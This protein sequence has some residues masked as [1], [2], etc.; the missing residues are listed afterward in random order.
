MELFIAPHPP[1]LLPEIGQGRYNEATATAQGMRQLS[2]D[3]QR[4]QPQIIAMITPH[5]N[6]FSD[7]LCVNIEPMLTGDFHKFGRRDIQMTLDG[8]RETAL[9]YCSR[10]RHA[11]INCLAMDERSA[12]QYAIST[13]LDH[14]VMVPLYFIRQ[15]YSTFQLLHISIGFLEPAQMVEA[16][17]ILAEL[18]G[19]QN[20]IVF[21]GD[22]SHKLSDD[23]PYGYDASGPVYD[24][25]IVDAI[26]ASRFTRILTLDHHLVEKAGQCAHKPL[27]MMVGALEGYAAQGTVYSY[28]G[29]FGV[30]YL[31][32]KIIRGEQGDHHRMRDAK[33][34][35]R[36]IRS[37]AQTKEDPYV[38]LA[39][40]TIEQYVRQGT[41]PDPPD[42]LPPEMMDQ[43]RGT[44]VSIKKNGRL[45]GCIGTISPTKKNIAQEIVGNAVAASTRDPRFEPIVPD[46]LQDLDISVDVLFP[47]EDIQDMSQLDVVKYGVIVT[48]GFR[49][50]LL[51]PNLDGVDTVE[52]QVA[53]ALQKAGIQPSESYTMQR[54]EVVRHQ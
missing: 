8:A 28:E 16:G 47:A 38:T 34:Q 48:Q 30:G 33:E 25:A 4:I 21:S 1:I 27:E 9:E 13:A 15:A 5:G 14:G 53:I 50:G 44:F 37:T 26:E 3:I 20:V 42:D 49:R 7:A 54:F 23:G 31:T 35:I 17:R 46:E 41:T 45:R 18:L 51:L 19:D 36:Q 22:L 10:L 40:H 24:Q 11:Q 52:E 2:A 43:R 12:V 6:V 39:R 29:P 32:A